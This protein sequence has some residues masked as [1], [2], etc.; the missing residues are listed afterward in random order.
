M[1][2]LSSDVRHHDIGRVVTADEPNTCRRSVY[3]K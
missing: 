2:S 1:P 3:V